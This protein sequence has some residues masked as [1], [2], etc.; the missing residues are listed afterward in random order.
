MKITIMLKSKMGSWKNPAESRLFALT[1]EP[2][3]DNAN[4]GN[5]SSLKIFSENFLSCFLENIFRT[6]VFIP[7]IFK[8]K[9]SSEVFL[10]RAPPEENENSLFSENKIF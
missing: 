8:I 6:L 9:K 2:D 3:L 10:L 5:F 7:F 4:V 1:L